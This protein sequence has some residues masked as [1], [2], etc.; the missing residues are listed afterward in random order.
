MREVYD[1]YGKRIDV[2]DTII[3]V[4]NVWKTGLVIRRNRQLGLI[5][6]ANKFTPFKHLSEYGLQQLEIGIKNPNFVKT[7]NRNL[8]EMGCDFLKGL[9][10]EKGPLLDTLENVQ[11]YMEKKKMNHGTAE[12]NL[13]KDIELLKKEN[14]K[15]GDVGVITAYLPKQNKF[16]V[17]FTNDRWLT[18]NYDKKEF[19]ENFIITLNDEKTKGL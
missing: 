9:V 5:N 10:V 15:K 12:W 18:F 3:D 8:L 7:D 6:Y 19:Y 2:G 1:R 13:E 17:M 11:K 16:A 4:D 14:V